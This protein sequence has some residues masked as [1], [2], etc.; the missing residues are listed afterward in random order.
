MYFFINIIF[1][2][3]F[4][5]ILKI[6]YKLNNIFSYIRVIKFYFFIFIF[7]IIF[8]IIFDFLNMNNSFNYLCLVVNIFLFIS[9]IL[10]IGIKFINSPS[11]YIIDFLKKNNLCQKKDLIL[12]LREKNII[13]KRIL[14][15]EK[16]NLLTNK[17]NRLSLTKYGTVFSSVF[18]FIKEVMGLES[19]G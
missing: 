9:Y 1:I 13:E 18:F 3:L 12:K 15:L 16:E 5:I 6:D 19:E 8:S 2:L 7:F 11:Y 4:I 17:D 10:T 14:I